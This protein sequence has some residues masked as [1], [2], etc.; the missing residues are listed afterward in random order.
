MAYNCIWGAKNLS[1]KDLLSTSTKGVL[2]IKTKKTSIAIWGVKTIHQE[3][4]LDFLQDELEIFNIDIA[5]LSDTHWCSDVDVVFQQNGY[6]IIHSG[7]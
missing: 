5:G 4:Q 7:R 6:T 2:K 3:G 1:V